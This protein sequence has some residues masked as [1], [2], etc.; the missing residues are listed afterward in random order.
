MIIDITIF[1]NVSINILY[2]FTFRIVSKKKLMISF[3]SK[4]DFQN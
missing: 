1:I 3:F 4:I 2:L